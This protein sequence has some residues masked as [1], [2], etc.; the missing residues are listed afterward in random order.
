M[1]KMTDPSEA[2]KSFQQ[3]LP[4]GRLQ[5]Q[6]G[7][8]DAELFVH[9][10]HP[11]GKPRFTYVRIEHLT[12]TVLV[13]FVLGDPIEGVPCFSVGYAVPEAYRNQGRAKSAV[14]AAIS[15]LEHG[16]ARNK[17]T[18]FWVEAIV[19]VDNEASQHV[20]AATISSAAIAV[21]DQFSG[22][23]ALHYVQ[24]FGKGAVSSV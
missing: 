2:L 19:G 24:K 22:L 23:P 3:M 1:P 18:A 6:P 12:V 11:N 7:A 17:V 15:E 5:L 10:D 4:S 21:T 9:L 14:T 8:I 16:M 13:V 20:A